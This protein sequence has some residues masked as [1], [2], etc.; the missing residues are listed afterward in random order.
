MQTSLS[1]EIVVRQILNGDSNAF[2]I[3]F[4][5]YHR[6]VG[7]IVKKHIP[8]C[9]IDEVSQEIFIKLFETLHKVKDVKALPGFI[10]SL[11]IRGSYDYY[12]KP[13]KKREFALDDSVINTANNNISYENSIQVESLLQKESQDF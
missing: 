8:I 9:D 13:H 4:E 5:R 6:L 11:S 1:D 2:S 10:K 12:R 7:S 3:L